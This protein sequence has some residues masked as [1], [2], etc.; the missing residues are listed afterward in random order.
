MTSFFA[1]FG[2]GGG[3]IV[4]I[5]VQNAF[6]LRQG[7]LRAHVGVICLLCALSDT[8]LIVAGVAGMGRLAESAPWFEPVMRYAGAAFLFWYGWRNAVQA[9]RGTGAL[10]AAGAGAGSLRAAVVTVLAL[11]WL[12]PHVYL[13][14]VVLVGTIS[15][16]YDSPHGFAAGAVSASF[17]WFFALGFGARLLR[18][19]FERAVAWQM[20]DAVIAVTMWAI[21]ASLLWH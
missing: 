9:W 13:D 6:V 8:I 12:N 14:T 2:L 18:P 11:T 5:G 19:F 10:E 21:A 16:Q 7:L 20:L 17:V 4:A 15:A 1:G 3:L